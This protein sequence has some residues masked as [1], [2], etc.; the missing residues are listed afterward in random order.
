M[1]DVPSP[2]SEPLTRKETLEEG[3][4][5]IYKDAAGDMP[6]FT[7]LEKRGSNKLTGL[8]V[9]ILLVLTVASALAW[10]GFF[11]VNTLGTDSKSLETSIEGPAT[12]RAGE[13]AFYT[14][15][16]R[17]TGNVPI[18]ALSLTVSLPPG[19]ELKE[20]LPAPTNDFTWT[21]GSLTPSSDGAVTIRGR[22]R[23]AVPSTETIQA[24]FNYR[25]ANFSSEFQDL[26]TIP[27]SINDSSVELSVTGPEKALPGDE[28]TYTIEVLN[29]T[30]EI[31][32]GLVVTAKLPESFTFAG[33]EPKPE[34]PL[35]AEWK[36]AEL[37]AGETRSITV[38]GRY[39]GSSEG[40][41]SFGA[42]L[43]FLDTTNRLPLATK[44]VATDLLGGDLTFHLVVNGSASDGYATLGQNLKVSIDYANRGR[45]LISGVSLTLAIAG[46]GGKA[47]PIALD[48]V[49]GLPEGMIAGG[50]MVFD[51]T[52]FPDIDSLDPNENGIID[53]N[54]PL[55]GAIDPAK[56]A[57]EL[58]L[59]LTAK[60]E[61][62]GSVASPRSIPLSPIDIRL[63]SNLA[64]SAEA[65]YFDDEGIPVGSG[66][67]PPKVGE[68]TKYR[69]FWKAANTLHPLTGLRMTT[70]LPPNV[71]WT[72]VSGGEG[73]MKFN[74]TTRIVS[75]EIPAWAADKTAA[76]AYFEVG[77]APNASDV[78]TF[79]KLTNAISAEATDGKNGAHLSR[80]LDILTS[81][82]PTDAG[83]K[84]K[85]VVID[86]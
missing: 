7:K 40:T 49:T 32:K 22:F 73:T 80:A 85:G 52:H 63:G 74:D 39:T 35:R 62:V 19:F 54:I 67:L 21:L 38:R 1:S 12:R 60:L 27:V 53:L 46:V 69:I 28:V 14:I 64:I 70:N 66:S 15:R 81:E 50:T 36:M 58:T 47:A 55:L 43:S 86:R 83:V 42:D 31:Q 45:E 8:L 68:S 29:T 2:Q 41:Q 77:V 23:S 44:Q 3:L 6:D 9:K 4:N 79:L 34:D 65:R 57:D 11:L 71:A 82:A 56:I 75:W 33:S 78:G 17:N 25:P 51:V 48:K 18:A 37:A 72:G 61:K 26:S 59:T 13:E 84:G 10:G 24:L 76:N 16:Y 5:S 30:R 20:T